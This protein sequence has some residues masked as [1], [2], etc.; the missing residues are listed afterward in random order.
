MFNAHQQMAQAQ[1]I[2]LEQN[3]MTSQVAIQQL[4]TYLGLPTHQQPNGHFNPNMGMGNM[5]TTFG[6]QRQDQRMNPTS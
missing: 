1:L 4:R 6:Q 2:F 3:L 5:G